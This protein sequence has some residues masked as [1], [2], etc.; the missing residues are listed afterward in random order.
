MENYEGEATLELFGWLLSLKQKFAPLILPFE[1][2]SGLLVYLTILLAHRISYLCRIS[3]NV[4]P[5]A[6]H[7]NLFGIFRDH[8]KKPNNFIPGAFME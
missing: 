6:R 5:S 3:Q 1:S 8:H 2:F 7:S 4:D